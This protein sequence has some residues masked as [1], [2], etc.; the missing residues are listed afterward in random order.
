MRRLVEENLDVIR[1]ELGR[2]PRQVSGYGLH[3]L[4]PEHGFD[5][6]KALAGSEGTCGVFTELTVALVRPLPSTA[7]V[8]LGYDDVFHA[9]AAVF[10]RSALVTRSRRR[11]KPRASTCTRSCSMPNAGR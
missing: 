8:V 11:A 7:L 6:A 2:F 10:I 1:T 3:Y 9:A 5:V 4:L